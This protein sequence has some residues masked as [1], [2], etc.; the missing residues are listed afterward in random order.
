MGNVQDFFASLPDARTSQSV[1]ELYL[2][3]HRGTLTSQAKVKEN[4]RRAASSGYSKP[5]SLARLLRS[6]GMISPAIAQRLLEDPAAQS[7]S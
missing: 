6:M 3:L 2:E 5:R 4:N 7:V 1:G